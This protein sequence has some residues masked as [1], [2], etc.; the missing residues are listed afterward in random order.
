M[1]PPRWRE[2]SYQRGLPRKI[3]RVE[4]SGSL[5]PRFSPRTSHGG[6]RAP[7]LG[8]RFILPHAVGIGPVRRQASMPA[9]VCMPA[10]GPAGFSPFLMPP[11]TEFWPSSGAHCGRRLKLHENARFSFRPLSN[12]IAHEDRRF[13]FYSSTRRQS[14][15]LGP[16]PGRC[17]WIFGAAL[18]AGRFPTINPADRQKIVPTPPSTPPF[19]QGLNR[20]DRRLRDCRNLSPKAGRFF[21]LIPQP[22]SIWASAPIG[23]YGAARVY[24][25]TSAPSC[26]LWLMPPCWPP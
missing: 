2:S 5:T 6:D 22:A 24:F 23:R 21:S 14:I 19:A 15:R 9:V 11:A 13:S 12:S 7:F 16:Q 18:V 4:V 17:F 8:R 26:S 1:V 25:G 10:H 20:F 3:R